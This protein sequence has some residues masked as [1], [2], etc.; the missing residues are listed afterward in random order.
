[1]T[2]PVR[3]LALAFVLLVLSTPVHAQDHS[4]DAK[5]PEATSKFLLYVENDY[6]VGTDRYYTNAIKATLLSP[7]LASF[8]D[9][10]RLGDYVARLYQ[11][12]PYL[13]ESGKRYNVGLSLG[14]QLY[15]PEDITLAEPPMDDQPYAAW[16]YGGISLHAKD[17][18]SMNTF[19]LQ[20]GWV[21]PGALG[22]FIQSKY[23][24]LIGADI[25]QGWHN[26]I[27]DEPGILLGAR[28][29]WRFPK[30]L[31]DGY[32]V[33]FLPNV[34]VVVGNVHTYA[35]AGFQARI[36]YHLPQDFGTS[37]IRPSA[38][39]SVPLDNYRSQHAPWR[40][41]LYM[42]FEGRLVARNIFLDGNTW[43]GSR[44]VDKHTYVH[45]LAI[46]AALAYRAYSLSYSLVYRSEEFKGQTSGQAFGSFELGVEF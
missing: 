19:E 9:D 10:P 42:G 32:G 44:S 23:H 34:A 4:L 30:D 1:M 13:K 16:L 7:E 45:D 24:A 2:R 3:L 37:L 12:V 36:G 43:Q 33:D 8:E 14:H 39:V 35:E 38:G 17:E 5:P 21:G 28:K 31:G 11:R 41:Y 26:Q 15:S 29:D 22:E 25:P 40:A 6:F 18:H 20:L 46:G 27:K